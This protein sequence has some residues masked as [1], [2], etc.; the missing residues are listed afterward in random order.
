M[1]SEY[2][3][4]WCVGAYWLIIGNSFFFST[5][6]LHRMHRKCL[7]SQSYIVEHFIF[8]TFLISHVKLCTGVANRASIYRATT[9]VQLDTA[10][11][12]AE[13]TIVA[14]LFT[15]WPIRWGQTKRQELIKHKPDQHE[16]FTTNYPDWVCVCASDISKASSKCS[17]QNQIMHDEASKQPTRIYMVHSP[18]QAEQAQRRDAAG[19]G[20]GGKTCVLQR[21]VVKWECHCIA[22]T[23]FPA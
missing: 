13:Q 3:F 12:H 9:Q 5:I 15:G 10:E 16:K 21:L 20:G 7:R 18:A 17:E 2:F 23:Y 6:F 22:F 14:R 1:Y 8:G 4:L 11:M 19:E